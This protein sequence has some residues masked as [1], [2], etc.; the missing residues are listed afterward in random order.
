M[1]RLLWT[2]LVCGL[3]AAVLSSCGGGGGIALSVTPPPSGMT[4]TYTFTG[5]TPTAAAMQTG[6]SAFI[7]ATIQSGAVS[8]TVPSGTTTSYSV[9]YVCPPTPGFGN[10]VT[11]EYVIEATTQDPTS[12]TVSCYGSAATTG[13][14]TGSVDAT[15]ISGAANVLIRGNQGYGGSVGASSGTF[16][17]TLPTG[18]NDVALIVE[19]SATFPNVLAVKILRSQTVPGAVNSGSGI[20]FTNADLTTSQALTVNNV[21]AGFVSPP[22]VAVEYFTSNGT[23]FLLDNNSATQYP[24]VPAGAT[25]GADYYSFESNSD[26]TAT[27]SSAVGATQYTATPGN[28]ATITL[29]AAWSFTGPTPA[30]LPTFTFNYSAFSSLA[31]VAQQG[32]IEWESTPTTLNTI[33]VTATANYQGSATTLAIPDL[34][35]VT[36]FMAP[37]ASGTNIYWVADVFGGTAQEFSAIPSSSG[38]LSFVQ[39]EGSYTQP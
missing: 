5:G 10:T 26:D 18:T 4:V 32:E 2:P 14:A 21:P 29:P 1:Q 8:F 30:T 35:S 31:A 20:T 36:G 37:A 34:S 24:A 19:D 11:S 23:W 7:P 9:A 3:L 6:T 33:T 17:V 12:S 15:A 22:A 13:S 27:H 25:Q 38:S 39:N 28:P 16:N